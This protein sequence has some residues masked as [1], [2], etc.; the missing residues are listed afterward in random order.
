M[1][2]SLA[3]Q[4][5]QGKEILPTTGSS[6]QL[7]QIPVEFRERAVFS[8][9]TN[10]ARHVQQIKDS[11]ADVLSGETNIASARTKL[12]Q[13][14]SSINYQPDPAKRG[15]L[16]DLSSDT[17]LNLILKTNTTQARG[18]TY[19]MQ[20]QEPGVI[21]VWPAQ[22]LFRAESRRERRQWGQI[23]NQAIS[24]LGSATSA[25]RVSDPFA[26]DGMIALK[27]DPIWKAI[28]V[29]GTDYP[30]FDYGSGM[31]LRDVDYDTAL[32]LGL[33][34]EDEPSQE[35]DTTSFNDGLQ[36]ASPVTDPD[37]LATLKESMQ[38]IAS[39]VHGILKFAP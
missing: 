35:R 11:I 3:E 33:I 32:D 26:N 7:T 10:N 14:L 19:K 9:K 24:S 31:R 23:W 20:G 4:I 5:L 38:G 21:D 6:A 29:F 12:K 39:I 27:N 2:D 18:H 22:E 36:V 28:S 34:K 1:P 17:R 13:S 15:G 37:L 30:P 8:A 25:I 16:Q